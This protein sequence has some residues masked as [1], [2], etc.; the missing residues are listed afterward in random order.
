M[1]DRSRGKSRKR[2]HVV[3]SFLDL[4]KLDSSLPSGWTVRHVIVGLGIALLTTALLVKYEFQTIPDYQI[5]EIAERTLEATQDF[6]VIDAVATAEKKDRALETIPVVFTFDFMVNQGIS[7]EIRMDFADARGLLASERS[8]LKMR[9]EQSFSKND[10]AEVKA[11]L[12]DMLPRF[13]LGR[14]I[15]ICLKHE[16]SQELEDQLVSLLFQSMKKPGVVF[17]RDALLRYRD[18]GIVLYDAVTGQ[19]E[20][21][22]DWLALR[23]LGQAKDLLKQQEYELTVV[24]GEDKKALLSFLE[25]WVVPNTTYDEAATREQEDRVLSDVDPVLIQVKK[26]KTIVRAGDEISARNIDQIKA[27]KDLR[28]K[29]RWSDR[30]IGTFLIVTLFYVI[31]WSYFQI[32]LLGK[33]ESRSDFLLLILVMGISLLITRA[34]FFLGE[35]VAGALRNPELQD[36]VNLFLMAPVAMGAVLTLLLVGVNLSVFFTVLFAVFVSL[37]TGEV[38]LPTYTLIGSLTAI[39]ALRQYRERSALIRAG[40]IIAGI[41]VLVAL[42]LQLLSTN[43][44]FEWTP[45]L[46]RTG[47]GVFS[48]LSASMLTSLL[49]P[50]LESLFG[51]TT[52][53]RLLELSNLNSPILRRM[54]LEAP[55]T[56]HHSITV[57]TLA[58]AGA[59]AIGANTLLIRVGAYYHDIGKMKHPDYYVENQIFS[60]NK[61]ENLSPTMSSLILSS[62]V[63]DGLAIADEVNLGPKVAALIPQHHGTRVMTYFYRKAKEAAEEK[64]LEVNEDDFRYPGP[65]PQSKEAA[66]LM[67]ADQVE[68][69]ARTLQDPTPGQVRGL[70]KRISQAT[71]Q[72][73]QFDECD[74]TLK[75][76]GKVAQ[77][78]ERVLTGM[79]HHRI[80]YP[81]FNFNKQQPQP[82]SQVQRQQGEEKQSEGERLQ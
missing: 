57:G 53:I 46:V 75:E 65:K 10:L 25:R 78:F 42:A 64:N 20:P 43:A 34:F 35:L 6:T 81:G 12:R 14:T 13:V 7:S 63:K 26:G 27:L 19:S 47:A 9:P 77:A 67:L 76:L 18:R 29:E 15:D 24:S 55:G 22:G 48:G 5:G 51:L 28:L 21:L 49:L 68:A 30:I 61:H 79:Y 8:R 23:D 32:H 45:F 72:D 71:I 39:Y 50:S 80:E 3:K 59:S 16:F 82:Q 11:K 69:A 66:I 58:E 31:L 60:V 17:N 41:N 1:V 44:V 33:N 62:H 38:S 70:I 4:G 2:G 36:P 56:Y 52:D 74:I 73:E 54:A 40:M 37:L